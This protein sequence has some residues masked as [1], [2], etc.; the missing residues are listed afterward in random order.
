M[1]GDAKISDFSHTYVWTH[2]GTNVLTNANVNANTSGLGCTYSICVK[3][4]QRKL[5]DF[6]YR[7]MDDLMCVQRGVRSASAH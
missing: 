5:Y 7:A 3:E 1:I 2:E 4:K 6:F